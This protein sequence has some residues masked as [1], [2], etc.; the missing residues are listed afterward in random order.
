[1]RATASPAEG[2]LLSNKAEEVGINKRDETERSFQHRAWARKQWVNPNTTGVINYVNLV[3]GVPLENIEL[4]I[5]TGLKELKYYV[6]F[7]LGAGGTAALDEGGVA[8]DFI[9]DD[10]K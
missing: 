5:S 9:F 1:M 4:E 2:W 7:P 8:Q 3:T 6:R 10:I